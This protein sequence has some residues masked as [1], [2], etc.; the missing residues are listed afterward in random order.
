[1]RISAD[2][3]KDAAIMV[4]MALTIT[5]VIPAMIAYALMRIAGLSW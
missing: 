4:I 3:L 1:M 5:G 2:A